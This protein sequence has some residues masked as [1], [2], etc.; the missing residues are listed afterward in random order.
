MTDFTVRPASLDDAPQLGV[1]GPASYA[2]AYGYLWPEPGPLMQYLESYGE[3]A[4]RSAM[5]DEN[6]KFWLA[7]ADGTAIGFAMAIHK[8]PN[9]ATQSNTG[10]ELK[11]VYLLSNV[12]GSGLG[13]KLYEAVEADAK[14]A[15]R[16]HIWLDVMDSA[17][18]AYGAYLRWGF[19][20]IGKRSFDREVYDDRRTM[21]LLSKQID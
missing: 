11:R 19:V 17:D 21:I 2:A 5:E 14:Q 12:R 1:V 6:T 9:P 4:V 18:W 20:E 15:G 8:S 10:V 16:D 7:E 3:A 13:K